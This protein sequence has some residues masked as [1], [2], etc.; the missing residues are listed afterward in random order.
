MR[1]RDN[2]VDSSKILLKKQ[3]KKSKHKGGRRRDNKGD[4]S[5]R[6]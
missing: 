6:K 2:K 1:S 3:K 4:L 5:K